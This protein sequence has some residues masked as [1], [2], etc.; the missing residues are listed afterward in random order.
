MPPVA[1]FHPTWDALTPGQ[2]NDF[3]LVFVDQIIMPLDRL[4]P[5]F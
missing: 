1:G 3:E 5:H 4:D 2:E